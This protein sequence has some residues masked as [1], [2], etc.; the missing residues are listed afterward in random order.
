MIHGEPVAVR[1]A[2]SRLSTAAAAPTR[3]VCKSASNHKRT[4]H[5]RSINLLG[6]K[7]TGR[8]GGFKRDAHRIGRR[9]EEEEAEEGEMGVGLGGEVG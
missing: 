2:T 6:G 8:R 3:G 5:N 4:T 7:K 9:E 1:R